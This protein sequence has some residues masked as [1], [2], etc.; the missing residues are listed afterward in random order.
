MIQNNNKNHNNIMI[1]KKRLNKDPLFQLLHFCGSENRACL[2]LMSTFRNAARVDT[3]GAAA[4]APEITHFPF[5]RSTCAACPAS[6]SVHTNKGR[7]S[8]TKRN[9]WRKKRMHCVATVSMKFKAILRAHRFVI[10]IGGLG[11]GVTV[12][13]RRGRGSSLQ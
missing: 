4:N 12:N 1:I 5:P 8:S 11:W 2:F 13:G 10:I 3:T 6:V 9:R 7:C